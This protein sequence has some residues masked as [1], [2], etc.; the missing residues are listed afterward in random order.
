MSTTKQSAMMKSFFAPK[1]KKAKTEGGEAGAAREGAAAASSSSSP[2]VDAEAK[3]RIAENKKKAQ[4]TRALKFLEPISDAGWRSALEG[5]ASKGYLFALAEFVAKERRT[6]T[7]FPPPER[8]FAA[9]DACPLSGVKV[10][11]V[12]QDPYHGPGQAHGLA[13]SVAAGANCKFPPSLRN[14][15]KEAAD[16][17]GATMPPAGTGD[18]SRWAERGVLLLN[19]ALTVRK[20]EANSH[21]KVGWEKFT[22]AVV[23]AVN[24]RKGPGV[25]F[26]LWG[27]PALTKCATIDRKKHRVVVSSHPSPLSNTKTDAPFTGSRVFSRVNA[28]LVSD[29]GWDAGVDWDL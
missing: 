27:K 26:V 10:V 1:A 19:T 8:T 29:L 2:G 16:D 24:D 15:L 20:G 23:R 9:L 13:F 3:K 14:I 4:Q 18:L 5:E 22:D 21:Q 12:G 6:K 7:V 11:V 25:V 28:H 17:V